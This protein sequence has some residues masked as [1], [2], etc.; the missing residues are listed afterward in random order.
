[1]GI[2]T[3][4]RRALKQDF[5]SFVEKT[6]FSIDPRN[7]PGSTV[8]RR[9]VGSVVQ[10]FEIQWEKYGR[11]RF[12]LHFGTCAAAGLQIQGQV[13]HTGSVLPTW[14]PDTGSLQPRRGTSSRSWFRQDRPLLQR[15]LLRPAMREPSEVVGEVLAL[16]PEL[17]RYWAT[18]EVGKHMRI[19]NHHP[20]GFVQNAV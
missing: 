1:M 5:F 3:G 6:G 17:E 8:F 20:P 11:P 12:A 15:L 4:L 16:F 14:C 18:G 9:S 2:T 7:Q 10:I 13:H 19:W